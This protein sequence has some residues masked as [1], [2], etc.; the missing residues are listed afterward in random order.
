MSIGLLFWVL[1][2]ISLF[3]WWGTNF[4]GWGGPNGPHV[5][6]FML[7]VLLFLLGWHDFGF[8]IHQ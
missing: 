4:Q 2:I 7:F 6:G 1:M 5:S 8:V 3:G